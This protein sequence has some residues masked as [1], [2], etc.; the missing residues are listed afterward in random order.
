MITNT[1]LNKEESKGESKPEK[2]NGVTVFQKVH[3]L[4]VV[5]DANL[6]ENSQIQNLGPNVINTKDLGMV[7]APYNKLIGAEIWDGQ[8]KPK[9]NQNK[10]KKKKKKINSKKQSELLMN[11]L[12]T[13]FEEIK[14]DASLAHEQVN[15][16]DANIFENGRTFNNQ[17]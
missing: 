1:R 2:D 17:T 11:R 10:G 12:V 9:F 7:N 5:L 3:N 15:K 6:P 14:I 4:H 16:R 13:D 8:I